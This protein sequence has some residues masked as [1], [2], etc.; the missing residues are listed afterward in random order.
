MHTNDCKVESCVNRCNLY[1]EFY[2]IW[3]YMCN[4]RLYICFVSFK[5]VYYQL[6][7]EFISFCT[8]DALLN[9]NLFFFFYLKRDFYF[10]K[11]MNSTDQDIQ[12]THTL[13]HTRTHSHTLAHTR[14]HSHTHTL[15]RL[16]SLFA[17]LVINEVKHP[18]RRPAHLEKGRSDMLWGVHV[19]EFEALYVFSFI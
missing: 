16:P 7:F 8:S 15:A 13:A 1:C 12:N 10:C 5:F 17:H 4:V 14:T 18:E 3:F 2:S 11:N 19:F 9:V 6:C